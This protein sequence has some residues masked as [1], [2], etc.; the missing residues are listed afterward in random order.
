RGRFE[1]A[2]LVAFGDPRLDLA[3]LAREEVANR[4][5]EALVRDVVRAV[6]ERGIE[7]AQPLVFAAGARL[8]ARDSVGDAMLDRRVVADVEVQVLQVFKTSPVASIEHARFLQVEGP[9]HQL[10]PAIGADQADVA[11]EALAH[12]G[13]ELACQVTAAPVE[14]LDRGEVEIEHRA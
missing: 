8:E 3:P 14:F 12:L 13:E 5:A 2:A 4:A 1:L 10:A 6:R 9:G 11:P 7:A